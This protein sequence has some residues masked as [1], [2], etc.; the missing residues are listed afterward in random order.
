MISFGGVTGLGLTAE[1]MEPW[2]IGKQRNQL[3]EK[4]LC[5]KTRDNY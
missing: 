2:W 3:I 5:W 1:D 4:E